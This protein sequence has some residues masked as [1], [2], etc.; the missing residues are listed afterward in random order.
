VSGATVV[1]YPVFLDLA[2]K[3]CLVVGGGEVA[4]GKVSGLLDAGARVVVVSP[5]LAGTLARLVAAGA[6]AHRAREFGEEDLDGMALV[7]A[8]TDQPEVNAAACRAARRR[9]ILVNVV[10]TPSEC[11]FYTPAV[12]RRGALQIA[13]STEGKS[14]VLARCI[15][16][17]LE[18]RF[19]PEY[20]RYLEILGR[21][22]AESKRR[23]D[24]LRARTAALRALAESGLLSAVRAGDEPAIERALARFGFGGA[25]PSWRD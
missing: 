19:G 10:D 13:V 16:E 11:D 17:E 4:A 2:G 6:V 3:P 18:A 14:P 23:G 20:A 21:A 7:I 15:R 9:R 12:V 5:G 8:A 24:S 1:H 25:H 22:R